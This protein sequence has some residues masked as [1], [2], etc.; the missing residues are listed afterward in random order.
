MSNK[1]EIERKFIIRKPDE[2]ALS[3]L[4]GYT[5]SE[6]EQIYLASPVGVTHRI[7]S[8]RYADRTEYTETVKLRIDKSSA[9]ELESEITEERFLELSRNIA[10]GTRPI[11]KTR[12]TFPM[13]GH[14][15]EIDVYPEWQSTCILEVELSHRDEEI[16]FPSLI[17]PV[18]EV[19][20]EKPYSNASMSR[21]FPPEQ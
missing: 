6:I 14:V 5:R 8:R 12:H 16:I 19:T 17:S 18:R 21:V 11:V 13:G 9:N 20:G 7:R 2:D 3:R 1:V 15:F 10:D 4:N